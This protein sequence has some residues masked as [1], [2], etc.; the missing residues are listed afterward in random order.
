MAKKNLTFA[1][2]ATL[3][4]NKY[5]KYKGDPIAEKTMEI[6]LQ[7]LA[8]EQES[9][10]EEMGI[11]NEQE[12]MAYGGKVK[13]G[14]GG[15]GK[16]RNPS[17]PTYISPIGDN[18]RKST[19]GANPFGQL[20]PGV[21]INEPLVQP[22]ADVNP[23]SNTVD[24]GEPERVGY[25]GMLGSAGNV[26]SLIDGLARGPQT[27][28]YER[29]TPDFID[30]TQRKRD[31]RETINTAANNVGASIREGSLSSGARIGATIGNEANRSRQINNALNQIQESVD[32]TN[33]QTANQFEM[34]NTNLA[35]EEVI[36]NAQNE[37]AFRD[38]IG[39]DINTIGG[40]YAAQGAEQRK[41]NATHT[42]NSRIINAINSGQLSNFL[43]DSMLE[44][45]YKKPN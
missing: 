4:M 36:A 20:K 16:L 44:M 9:K 32:T 11:P 39:S 17:D 18:R 22:S 12:Q 14:F 2:R 42:M 26:Y 40:S 45:S 6:E 38:R 7:E 35:R 13:K 23:K 29:A 8:R 28:E 3:I 43:M 10:K 31:A 19:F 41:A 37:A 30:G 5:K 24:M 25:R 33:T 34:F 27:E 1:D 21:D 15:D